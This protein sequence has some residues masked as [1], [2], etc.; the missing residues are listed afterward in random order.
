MIRDNF[1]G[2]TAVPR[3]FEEHSNDYAWVTWPRRDKGDSFKIASIVQKYASW[4]GYPGQWTW[5]QLVGQ[6]CSNEEGVTALFPQHEKDH[7]MIVY[8]LREY[9]LEALRYG[10]PLFG[11]LMSLM[12]STGGVKRYVHFRH[13]LVS[14]GGN[15]WTAEEKRACKSADFAA[16]R[17]I[18]YAT[19][20]FTHVPVR[21][22]IST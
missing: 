14:S 18:A 2:L 5:S 3:Q 13:V 10:L 22:S 16:M 6:F 7:A 11:V 12:L 4:L 15:D 1:Y 8:C 20:D 21:S 9:S 17:D 19:A